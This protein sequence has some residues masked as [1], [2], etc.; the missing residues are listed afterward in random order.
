[1]SEK[2]MTLL[3][4]F[5]IVAGIVAYDRYMVVVKEEFSPIKKM[6]DYAGLA[7]YVEI[8][9]KD[10]KQ[11]YVSFHFSVQ[12]KLN[13][14]NNRMKDI[15]QERLDLVK[16]RNAVIARFD[17]INKQLLAEAQN[18]V[19]VIDRER[20]SFIE[21]FASL[22]KLGNILISLQNLSDPA[23]QQQYQIVKRELINIFNTVDNDY[24]RNTDFLTQVFS[25]IDMIIYEEG[26]TY[27][28]GCLNKGHCLAL[29]VKDIEAEFLGILEKKSNKP[30]RDI[31]ELIEMSAQ[32]EY[33]GKLLINNS[34]ATE[35]SLYEK[36]EKTYGAIKALSD[37]LA[38]LSEEQLLN[39]MKG[40][41]VVQSEQGKFLANLEMNKKRFIEAQE[42]SIKRS[43]QILNEIADLNEFNFMRLSNIY[44]GLKIERENLLLLFM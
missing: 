26:E 12:E 36:D 4:L 37:D 33:E 16:K 23:T 11:D 30:A 25:R 17:E 15:E 18:Y 24:Q 28:E 44:L 6:V 38:D 32:L 13:S 14:W 21:R 7:K 5:F 27:F 2:S 10:V 31:N 35:A 8:K 1:M 29:M 3:M 41:E 39:F 42:N 20:S 43:T 9:R 19:A 22:R 40:Y 34:H